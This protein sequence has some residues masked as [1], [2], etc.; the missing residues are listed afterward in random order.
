MTLSFSIGAVRRL[1][2]VAAFVCSTIA[3]LTMV[4]HTGEARTLPATLET[5]YPI[6]H[7]IIIDKE[8]RSFDNLFG[9]FP[10]ADGTTQAMTSDGRT[11]AL[12]RTPDHTL[13]DVA[14]AGDAAILAVNQGRMNQFNLLPGAVQDG[15]D[16]ADSQFRRSDIPNYWRY[17]QRFALDD[18]L[19]ATILGPSFPNHLVTVAATSGNTIDNPRG[20]VVHGWGCDG[21][22]QSLVAGVRPDGTHFLTRPCFNFVTLPDRLTRSGISWKYYSPPPFASGY[23][24]NALDAIKHVRF[25]PLW[26]RNVPPDTSFIHD[27]QTGHLARVNWLVTN[28]RQSDHPPA[29]ICVGENWTV[30]VINAVMQSRYWK[31][32]AIFLIWDD[33]GGFYDHVPPPHLSNISLG[34]RVPGIVISPFARPH[35]IDHTT[36]DFNSILRF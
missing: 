32:T 34:P 1:V 15:R 25:S 22:P 24:W 21:G 27:V 12:G 14:H 10:G 17:A 5:N 9:R 20:Q 13:L 16:I 30:S 7:I 4:R 33:F 18:H 26:S 31:D 35:S 8:N 28:T 19:F 29:S 11:I 23:I 6:K 3:V 36:L 2:L